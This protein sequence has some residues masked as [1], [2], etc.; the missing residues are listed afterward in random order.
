MQNVQNE[1]LDRVSI[2]SSKTERR[3]VLVVDLV[4]VLVETLVVHQAVN[5]VVPC[6][7]EEEEESDL[8]KDSMSKRKTEEREVKKTN[9]RN[10]FTEERREGELPGLHADRGSERLEKV[11]LW[12]G[13]VNNTAEGK[14][15]KK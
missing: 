9:L 7:L 11:D 12:K 13:Q 14:R 1:N 15:E 5:E 10:H 4:N 8:R 3:R 2:L 6:V